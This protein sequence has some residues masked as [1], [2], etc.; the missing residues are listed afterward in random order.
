MPCTPEMRRAPWRR[1]AD[2]RLWLYARLVE[3]VTLFSF[4]YWGWGNATR[5]LVGAVDAVEKARGF[6]P[7]LFVDVRISRSVR[8]E[9]FRDDAFE[10]VVGND[11]Y[12][13]MKGLGN[14]RVETKSGPRIHIADPEAAELLL[15]LALYANQ[16]EQRLLFYCACETPYVEGDSRSCHR[17]TVA[18]L[19]REAARGRGL[20]IETVEWPGGN[21][22]STELTVDATILRAVRRG[23]LSIPVTPGKALAKYAGLP[24][25]SAVHLLSGNE[26]LWALAGPA[27]HS[28]GKW[29]LPV[30]ELLDGASGTSA[31]AKG[32]A[33]RDELGFVPLRVGTRQQRHGLFDATIYTI[34]HVDKLQAAEAHGRR[35]T[36]TEG[37]CWTTGVTLLRKAHRAAVE[38]PILFADAAQCSRL[39]YTAVLTDIVLGDNE[40]TYS[41]E[42]LR[43]LRGNRRPQDLVL[44]GTGR[45]IAPH[46]IRPYAICE[47]PQFL[48]A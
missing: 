17:V 23:R 32:R 30:L 31:A 18:R 45:H 9:G 22:V 15:D 47:T 4:G 25:G 40:T 1:V 39:I 43:R 27:K 11:R 13:W 36:F 2:R 28:A 26:A 20:S 46:Y 19:V 6:R 5:E 14:R 24:W 41:F 8:A 3:P 44:M 35:G 7:P 37:R 29:Q 38:L 42:R 12:R 16:H 10:K 33:I 48:R 34:L 21:P